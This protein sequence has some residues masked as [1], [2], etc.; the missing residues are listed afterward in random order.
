MADNQLKELAIRAGRGDEQAQQQVML[1]VYPIVHKHLGFLLTFDRSTE[2]AVQE[3]MLQIYQALPGYRGDASPKSWAL[4]IAT[5]TARRYIGHEKK[6][7]GDETPELAEDLAGD[8]SEQWVELASLLQILPAKK[9]Q[10]MVLMGIM[11]LTAKEAAKV[12]RTFPNTASS[13]FRLAREELEKHL[14]ACDALPGLR[15]QQVEAT[16]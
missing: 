3:S 14:V 13:R 9:R 7:R 12:M 11:G 4:R 2:D 16:S 8:A 5:R 6:R 15:S 10:A 1:E